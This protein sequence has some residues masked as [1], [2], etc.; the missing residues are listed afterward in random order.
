MSETLRW[1]TVAPSVG[2]GLRDWIICADGFK[3]SI[4]ASSFHYCSPRE[5]GLD[6]YETVEIGF[7]S[8]REELLMDY[9]EDGNNPTSTVYGWVPVEIVDAVIRKHGGLI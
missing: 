3:M 2:F 7:P 6:N 4:Q 8:E 9:A 1:L 5:D